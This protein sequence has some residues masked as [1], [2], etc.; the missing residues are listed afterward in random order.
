L[1]PVTAKGID[2]FYNTGVELINEKK[3]ADGLFY[4]KSIRTLGG[5]GNRIRKY[6]LNQLS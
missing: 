1:I 2:F 6:R 4:L 3:Y 5:S